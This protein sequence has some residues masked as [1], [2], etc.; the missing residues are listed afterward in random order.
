MVRSH[1]SAVTV[2]LSLSVLVAIV[3]HEDLSLVMI[4]AHLIFHI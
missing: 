2:T 1:R 4:G 3:D